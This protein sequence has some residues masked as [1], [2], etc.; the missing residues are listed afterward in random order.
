MKHPRL[1]WR[2]KYL[3]AGIIVLG[4]VGFWLFPK[5]NPTPPATITVTRGTLSEEV[6]VTGLTK[7]AEKLDL[8]FEK[9]G[10]VRQVYASVGT[11]VRA[12]DPIAALDQS[13]LS[14][15]LLQAEA[16]KEA[17]EAK[18]VELKRGARPEDI[19][20]SRT[21][22][23]KAE[24]D[25][26]NQYM[27]VV[28]VLSTAY[29]EA[30]DAVRKQTDP[31]FTN[32]ETNPQLSFGV[33]NSQTSINAAASRI[34]ASAE[35]NN[36]KEELDL[37][38]SASPQSALDK[39]LQ[40]G[41]T[42]LGKIR[43]FL[44]FSMQA[45]QDATTIDSS[46]LVTYK[47]YV[48]TGRT[49]VNTSITN[50]T[51]KK[52][53]IA[54]AKIDIE[55]AQNELTLKLAG[56]D[57]QVIAAQ[58]AAVKEEQANIANLKAQLAKAILRSPIQGVVTKQDAKIGQVAPANTT[59]VSIISGDR[60]EVEANIPE[61][62]IA[63]VKVGDAAEV[64]LDAYGENV[65]FEAS[66]ISIEPAET[67]VEGIATYK[68]KFQLRNEDERVRP[69]MTANI[70]ILTAKREGILVIPQRTIATRNGKKVVWIYE[71]NKLTE[72]EI[73]TGLRGSDG[74]IE[75][76]SGLNEGDQIAASVPKE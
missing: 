64:T 30:D 61:I 13:E 72:K 28:D 74:N 58:V 5:G 34:S 63:K 66:V 51:D 21:G 8:S 32:D 69:G 4:I 67:V 7:P 14:A 11:K 43:T 39:A 9:G 38:S 22:L 60:L 49:N 75:V 29:S 52:E 71:N 44:D 68:T 70:E 18:L 35:L 37:L 19:Q 6:V 55:Q 41:T 54:E 46:T 20:V 31:L 73:V 16:S 17:A 33:S 40:G 26:D 62:D 12:G 24:Q 27:G 48:T 59:L 50:V 15:Q 42:R 65:L 1:W 53:E 10:I 57:P 45:L 23:R 36:W 25:L 2:N 56:S 76:T 47:S 3:I